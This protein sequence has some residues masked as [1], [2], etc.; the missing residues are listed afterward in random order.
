MSLWRSAADC[1]WCTYRRNIGY[2][3]G[4]TVCPAPD[5]SHL[6]SVL[7]FPPLPI[8]WNVAFLTCITIQFHCISQYAVCFTRIF[9]KCC[10]QFASEF[11]AINVIKQPQYVTTA[12]FMRVRQLL[13]ALWHYSP[14]VYYVLQCWFSIQ[15][16][17]GFAANVK[18]NLRLGIYA[19]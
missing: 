2:T 5:T 6:F 7:P 16:I 1:S 11:Q 9:S 14:T 8:L 19:A 13:T 12:Y 4:G 15:N 10:Q 18:W 3:S 17:T